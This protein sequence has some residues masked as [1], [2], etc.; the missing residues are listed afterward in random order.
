V[1]AHE[2]L[3]DQRKRDYEAR[4]VFALMEGTQRPVS[5][6]A[7]SQSVRAAVPQPE[8]AKALVTSALSGVEPGG[9]TDDDIYEDF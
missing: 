8:S 9:G 6:D 4:A 2:A 5:E 3:L 1:E 7:A